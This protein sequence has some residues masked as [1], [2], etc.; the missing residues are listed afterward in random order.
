MLW[1]LI[2]PM[3]SA[4]FGKVSLAAPVL[5]AAAGI[6]GIAATW[7]AIEITSKAALSTKVAVDFIGVMS[8]LFSFAPARAEE[9]GAPCP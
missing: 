6:A 9:L 1:Q 4:S 5:G 7:E 8:S 3:D 2:A